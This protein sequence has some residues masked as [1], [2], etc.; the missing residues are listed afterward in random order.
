MAATD[1]ELIRRF[2]EARDEGA[3]E[4][5]VRRHGGMVLGVA[6]RVLGGG[7]DSPE[8]EDAFQGTFLV[9]A[10]EAAKLRKAGSVASWLHG[11]ALRA[12]LKAKTRA[13]ARREHERRAAEML[14]SDDSREWR[15]TRG[16][17]DEEVRRLPERLRAPLVLCYFEEKTVEEAARDLGWTDGQIRGRLAKA[18]DVL[19]SRLSRRGVAVGA[20]ALA[21]LITKNAS[22]AVPEA[23][24]TSTVSA[25]SAIASGAASTATTGAAS[26]ANEMVRAMAVAK[27]K[28]VV[29]V[30]GAAAVVVTAVVV[31]VA[32]GLQPDVNAAPL[33]GADGVVADGADTAEGNT[34]SPRTR[35]PAAVVR[36][37]GDV[38]ADGARARGV[39]AHGD[40]LAAEWGLPGP[41]ARTVAEICAARPGAEVRRARRKANYEIYNVE[42]E[43]GDGDC[44]A[45]ISSDGAIYELTEDLAA[46]RLPGAVVATVG[47]LYPGATI[48]NIA[49]ASHEIEGDVVRYDL[50]LRV[51]PAPVNVILTADGEVLEHDNGED[52]GEHEEEDE[53]EDGVGVRPEAESVSA[54]G[55]GVF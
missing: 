23:Y 51:R 41:V 29:A 35:P 20:L 39:S 6:R 22:A 9:L 38:R 52:E 12:S 48:A 26:L 10:T 36:P 28:L 2:R 25:A 7:A 47:R 17:I 18:R 1:G 27:A 53:D 33:V 40:A 43:T 55:E 21:A 24:V 19:H 44:E 8:A 31:G 50:E 42:I 3:F 37:S 32:F 54:P 11:V 30:A 13:A 15:E 5:I 14:T 45:R 16:V 49:H 34:G 46:E 4:E